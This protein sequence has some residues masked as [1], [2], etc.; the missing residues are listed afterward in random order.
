MSR[1]AKKL[2]SLQLLPRE[3]LYVKIFDSSGLKFLEGRN[4][5]ELA[6]I[7]PPPIFLD[8]LSGRA[9]LGLM[10]TSGGNEP[11]FIFEITNYSSVFAGLLQWEEKMSADFK[12]LLAPDIVFDRGENVFKDAVVANNDARFLKNTLGEDALGYSIFNRKFLIISQSP[13]AIE[14]VIRQMSALPP[15]P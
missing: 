8:G 14:A 15:R 4:F 5:F 7:I 13:Q 6:G 9:T 2:F 10:D 1:V 12:D 3:F 11:V